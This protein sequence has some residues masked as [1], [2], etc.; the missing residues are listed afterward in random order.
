MLTRRAM[1]SLRR[2]R[3]RRQH[4]LYDK[5]AAYTM[6]PRGQFVE[7]LLVAATVGD[8]DGAIVECGTWRGGMSAALAEALPGRESVLFDSFEGLPPVEP[9]DGAAARAWQDAQGGEGEFANCTAPESD[10]REA[11]RRSGQRARI[12]PGWFADTIPGY[13]AERPRIAVLRLDADWYSSTIT[14][15]TELWTCVVPGGVV[16]VDDYGIWDGCTRAVHDHLARVG[17]VEPI[18]QTR[19]GVVYLRRR[20]DAAPVGHP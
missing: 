1:A 5:Y 15:L 6:I 10:A 4:A 12:V 7:N 3:Y 19:T 14:C 11:M 17:A 8:R 18:Q 13:A 16:L 9:I 20:P 2:R